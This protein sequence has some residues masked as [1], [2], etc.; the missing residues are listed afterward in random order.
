MTIQKTILENGLTIVTDPMDSVET[1][2]LGVWCGTGARH[3]KL[4]TNGVA[5]MVEHMVFKGT[6]TRNALQIS[7]EIENVGGRMNAY[8]GREVTAYY[9]HMLKD[10]YSLGLNI[11][12]DM[13]QNST[14]PDHEIE[15]ERGV[16]IQ[17]IGMYQDA[18][19]DHIFDI[20]QAEAFKGQSFGLPILGSVDT[21]QAMSKDTLFKYIQN[22]YTPQRM[23]ISAAGA[24]D[25][26]QLVDQVMSLFN[27]LPKNQERNIL[28]PHYI[29][30]DIRQ[31]RDLEQ[32]HIFLGF[33]NISY[34]D[35]DYFAMRLLS[36]ILGGSSSSRLF[37]EVRE[38]RG[39][40]YDICT[41]AM[42]GSD[43][44]L[45][46]IYAGTNP[47]EL[48]SLIPVITDEILKLTQTLKDEEIIRAKTQMKAGLLMSR[49][50]VQRRADQL[51]K[52]ILQTGEII[53]IK[54]RIADI[55]AV[56]EQDILRVAQK[57]F[58]T[59]PTVA[60]LGN[61]DHLDSYEHIVERLA[62]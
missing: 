9:V 26:D 1:V 44:G 18:P 25:H 16:I 33:E 61:L 53:D 45:F 47:H 2:S 13:L 41:Y 60:A 31:V 23:V 50:S 39:L 5:H 14:M 37:Q 55:D 12:A 35:P 54:K 20:A 22:N 59:P 6:N 43:T 32:T 11:I 27:K 46:A 29:A 36:S 3:E 24:I 10:D 48:S 8:T 15:R 21:I 62:A 34:H 49:E 7:E 17:E 56:K 4:H 52:S 57:I 42:S 30:G 58:S 40:A 28:K 38:K 51:G 19:D